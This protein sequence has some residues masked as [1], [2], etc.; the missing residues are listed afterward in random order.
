MGSL[1]PR[2]DLADRVVGAPFSPPGERS[3]G[4]LADARLRRPLRRNRDGARH[5]LAWTARPDQARVDRGPGRDQRA[6]RPPEPPAPDLV[7]VAATAFALRSLS[8]LR[9]AVAWRP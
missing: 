7:L 1:S 2:Q 5:R 3:P 8:S 4:L 9:C 6:R